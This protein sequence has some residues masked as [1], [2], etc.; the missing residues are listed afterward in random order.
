MPVLH[1]YKERHE[2][3][4][5]TS[6]NGAI[7]TFQLTKE[8]EKKLRSALLA[9]PLAVRFFWIFIALEMLTLMVQVRE[10]QS[11]RSTHAKC[12]LISQ[13]TPNL[14]AY[15]PHVQCVLLLCRRSPGQPQKR[16]F[17]TGQP[18]DQDGLL[19]SL[20]GMRASESVRRETTLNGLPTSF[21]A[22]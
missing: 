14:R 4:V 18:G 7:I 2:H 8:G 17:G 15:S 11:L 5:L 9:N 20:S 13:M 6:I 12:R 10:K 21:Y 16:Y 22:F 3:Y 19:P 1:R